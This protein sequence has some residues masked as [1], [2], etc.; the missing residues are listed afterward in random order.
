MNITPGY[1][2]GSGSLI[3]S[4]RT[5]VFALLLQLVERTVLEAVKSRFES[6]GGHQVI[7]GI[8]GIGQSH[9]LGPEG[10]NPSPATKFRIGSANQKHS[11]CN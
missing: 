9:K 7:A 6:E 5:K 1:E 4:G 11:T 10:S 3:L 8:Q 2:P